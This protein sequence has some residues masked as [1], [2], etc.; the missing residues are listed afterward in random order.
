MLLSHVCLK[1]TM[2]YTCALTSSSRFFHY[3]LCLWHHIMWHVMWLQW[4]VPLHCPKEKKKGKRNP[5]K[6]RKIKEKKI[7]IAGVQSV[8]WH[9]EPNDISSLYLFQPKSYL[10]IIGIS[11][12][13][14]N[15]N[16]LINSSMVETII[17][18][19]YIFNNIVFASKSQ[20]IKVL[21]KSDIVMIWVNI[22]DI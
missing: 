2:L 11:Y 10:K 12:L 6:V 15:T 21:P 1:A 8:S 16:T 20:V 4:H 3:V 18:N 19:L 13:M 17:K 14:K 9:I 7:K 22:W 5:Y